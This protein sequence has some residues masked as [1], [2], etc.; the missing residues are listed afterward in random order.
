MFDKTKE[1]LAGVGRGVRAQFSSDDRRSRR[2]KSRKKN[3][4]LTAAQAASVI[5]GAVGGV[6][7]DRRLDTDGTPQN[8]AES[9]LRDATD[10]MS[11]TTRRAVVVGTTTGTGAGVAYGLG[12]MKDRE[13]SVEFEGEVL[14]PSE[15]REAL[16]RGEEA[17]DEREELEDTLAERD[18]ALFKA[19]QKNARFVRTYKSAQQRLAEAGFDPEE[20][21]GLGPALEAA[22]AAATANLEE[23]AAHALFEDA[24][25]EEGAADNLDNLE[26]E[27]KRPIVHSKDFGTDTAVNILTQ[28][29]ASDAE[30]YLADEDREEVLAAAREMDLIE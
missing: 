9:M 22:L 24:H 12:R 16:H 15:V 23:V 8:T 3:A 2:G 28:V 29:D 21:G 6:F 19:R 18:E 4:A 14:S 11:D 1:Y 27:A 17:V 13:G 20:E 5:A 30:S 7:L 26:E 10:S 25:V